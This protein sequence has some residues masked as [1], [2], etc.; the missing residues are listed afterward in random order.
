M[1]KWQL[2]FLKISL[3]ICSAFILTGCN[4]NEKEKC[5][6]ENLPEEIQNYV[7]KSKDSKEKYESIKS[8]IKK[9]ED[10]NSE[11]KIAITEYLWGDLFMSFQDYKDQID[12]LYKES[13]DKGL[14]I[15]NSML[16]LSGIPTS[17]PKE[18]YQLFTN[19]ENLKWMENHLL[20]IEE[21]IYNS[22]KNDDLEYQINLSTS[23]SY[24]YYYLNDHN[25]YDYY[26]R[27]YNHYIE[28]LH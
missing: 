5:S 19:E 10:L 26:D 27:L 25:K 3:V 17:R 24:I 20:S 14:L 21:E 7:V 1:N 13:T 15:K 18:C 28:K 11:D 12:F 4:E 22:T 23:L 6:F 16:M 2:I 9:D 8:K